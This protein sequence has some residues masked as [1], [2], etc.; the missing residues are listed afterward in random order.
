MYKIPK[1]IRLPR[2]VLSWRRFLDKW[3][4]YYGEAPKKS[5]VEIIW[6][7]FQDVLSSLVSFFILNSFFTYKL[8]FPPLYLRC[9][10]HIFSCRRLFSY[11]FYLATRVLQSCWSCWT[12]TWWAAP[13][14][15]GTTSTTCSSD[16][17]KTEQEERERGGGG[18]GGKH[19]FDYTPNI[20]T[21][22]RG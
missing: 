6:L 21:H 5:R 10:N 22:K 20:H 15:R 13:S 4:L 17:D 8:D 9:T 18:G 3:N 16:S 19:K 11:Y 12:S 2:G 1:H 14:P 7:V